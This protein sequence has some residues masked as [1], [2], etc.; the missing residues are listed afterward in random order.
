LWSRNTED[1]GW[2]F[3]CDDIQKELDFPLGRGFE[4]KIRILPGKILKHVD[5][6][7]LVQILTLFL[8]ISPIFFIQMHSFLIYVPVEVENND[9][10]MFPLL[11]WCVSHQRAHFYQLLL[12]KQKNEEKKK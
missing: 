4:T 7:I 3:K 10:L 2:R 8:T 9:L 1:D 6:K 12:S 5:G 11:F